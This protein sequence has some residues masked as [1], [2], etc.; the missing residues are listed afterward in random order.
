MQSV[1]DVVVVLL[2][3]QQRHLSDLILNRE[4]KNRSWARSALE[5]WHY[6]IDTRCDD[7]VKA[8]FRQWS[9]DR[10]ADEYPFLL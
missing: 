4:G 2:L 5:Y 3:I 6:V 9:V 7:R 10:H 8:G 1:D